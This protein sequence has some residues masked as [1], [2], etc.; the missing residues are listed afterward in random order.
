MHFHFFMQSFISTEVRVWNQ[1]AWMQ[2]LHQNVH[3]SWAEAHCA[4][5]VVSAGCLF[6][7]VEPWEPNGPRENDYIMIITLHMSTAA[8]TQGHYHSSGLILFQSPSSVLFLSSLIHS[9]WST[10]TNSFLLSRLEFNL[11]MLPVAFF[12]NLDGPD[13][14]HWYV[15]KSREDQSE[16]EI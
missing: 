15:L 14:E 3:V 6:V 10:L 1:N 4:R 13:K 2:A 9:N 16:G 11:L 7:Q 8:N 12:N 5:S